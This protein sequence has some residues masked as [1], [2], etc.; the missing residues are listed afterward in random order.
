VLGFFLCCLLAACDGAKPAAP[1]VAA[2]AKKPTTPTY[3]AELQKLDAGIEHGISLSAKQTGDT[4]LQL[5]VVSLYQERA[6]LTGSYDDYAK[7][8]TLLATLPAVPKPSASMCLAE[9]RLHYT[10]HRLKQAATALDSC[11]ASVEQTEMAS[12]R[13]DLALY[14]GR[15]RDAENIYRAL[16][17]EPGI[18]PNFVRL[19][20]LK[21]WLG[22]PGEAAAL[23]EAA[24]KR[25]HAGAPTMHAWLK[26]QRGL[27]ALDRG[28]F[29]EAL[30]MYRLASDALDGWWLVDEHIAEV[31]HL[32]GTTPEAKQLYENI[33]ERTGN[34]EF[35]DALAAIERDLGNNESANKLRLKAH[36]IYEQRLIMFP[37]AAAGHALDHYLLDPA[38]A[39]RALSCAEEFRNAPIWRIGHRIG[40]SLDAFRKTRTR[41]ANHRNRTC[42]RMGYGAGVLDTRRSAASTWTSATGRAGEGT[43]TTPQSAQRKNVRL[44]GGSHHPLTATAASATALH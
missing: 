42:Q 38:D 2:A 8:A 5:Q 12:L 3:S 24:E 23:L 29:D 39:K 21:K 27:V 22:S 26:L 19:G 18:P 43:G 30:A 10:L 40:E 25:Y 4:L 31:L 6:R 15:Y 34:P 28:R 37:E 9:A 7:A 17:N 16:V 33:I 35:M 32:S 44:C 1:P 41:R 14:S 13:A 36:A 20:L 11:P